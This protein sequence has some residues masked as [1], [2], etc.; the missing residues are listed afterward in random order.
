M[1]GEDLGDT[2]DVSL[3]GGSTQSEREAVPDDK[4]GVVAFTNVAESVVETG[5]LG[6]NGS[7]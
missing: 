1:R 7:D 5:C 4:I 6:R 3:L 2:V